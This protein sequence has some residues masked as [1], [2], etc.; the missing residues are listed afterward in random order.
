MTRKEE[1]ENYMNKCNI[2]GLKI[3]INYTDEDYIELINIPIEMKTFNVP[4]F[5]THIG[6]LDVDLGGDS[7]GNVNI[8]DDK[9][10]SI[11]GIISFV[12][13]G[14]SFGLEHIYV[15]D[16]VTDIGCSA[17]AASEKLKTI[18]ISNNLERV[19]DNAFGKCTSLKEVIFGDKLKRL[20]KM[21]F[22]NCEN[23]RYVRLPESIEY[24]SSTS[25]VGCNKLEIVA[26]KHIKN[27]LEMCNDYKVTYY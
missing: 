10:Y 7:L 5:I 4:E 9:D 22:A 23:L 11:G 8:Q 14:K 26:P 15:S 16:S 1:Y 13:N 19:L 25:F 2:L 17:F 27:Q 18:R 12:S 6:T 20:E 24:V 3:D 21:A